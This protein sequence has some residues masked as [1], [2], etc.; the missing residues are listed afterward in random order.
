MEGRGILRK[1]ANKKN[2]EV[3]L[4]LKKL[5]LVSLALGVIL[6]IVDAA[7]AAEEFE[8]YLRIAG[9]PG[10]IKIDA[11]STNW[12]QVRGMPPPRAFLSGRDAGASRGAE[13]AEHGDFNV[14][15]D[16]DKAS[17]KLDLM[18]TR[19]THIKEAT[20]EICRA[21]GDK[22]F[23]RITMSDVVVTSFR[24]AG[25][26]GRMERVRLKYA[27]IKWRRISS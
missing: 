20:L 24:P 6:F 8:A 3:K 22:A 16:L 11:R 26:G 14:V 1:A 12:S 13:R 18:C 5:A 15:K 19:G 21:G 27:K 23:L 7:S 17:P 9:I 4:K 2:K 25:S 10:R